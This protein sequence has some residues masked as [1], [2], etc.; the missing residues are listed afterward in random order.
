[1]KLAFSTLGCP[2]FDWSDIYSMAK[3]CGFQG[4][5]LRGLGD[6]IFAYK[7]PFASENIADTVEFLK[8]RRL[9]IPCISSGNC[10]KYADK[11]EENIAILTEYIELAAKL[12]SSF[13][14]VLGDEKPHE[15]GETD[16]AIVA[17]VLM[18]LIP[19]AEKANVTL[20]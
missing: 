19:L 5:E 10:I 16:D 8:K 4:I 15:D 12:N 13:I 9:E 11:K 14:R 2:D 3:D 17:E 18:R 7:K 20:L 1:M 6:D